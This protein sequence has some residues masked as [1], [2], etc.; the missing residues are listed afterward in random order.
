LEITTKFSKKT[1]VGEEMV[2]R[3][4]IKLIGFLMLITIIISVVANGAIY[5]YLPELAED[6][7]ELPLF[8][9]IF[10]DES[11]GAVPFTVNFTSLV[12]NYEGDIAYY[13]E[14]GD[15]NTSNEISPSYTYV[16][17]NSFQC[18]LTVS[19]SAGKEVTDSVVISVKRNQGAIAII[20]VDPVVS[21]R[22]HLW[23]LPKISETYSGG[24]I[25]TI[26]NSPIPNPRLSNL[27]GW[28]SCEG[29]ATDPEGDEIVSYTWVLKP[30]SYLRRIGGIVEY[31]E[32]TF[33]GQNITIPG[34]Y[35][36]RLGDYDLI[37]TVE[38]ETG[39]T[40]SISTKFKIGTSPTENSI[41]QLKFR[42][43]NTKDMWL[44]Q[45]SKMAFAGL[46]IGTVAN[47]F[48]R[49]TNFPRAKIVALLLL[50]TGWLIS[51]EGSDTTTFE[52]YSEFLEKHPIRKKI[53]NTTLHGI[54]SSLE[55]IKDNNPQLNETLDGII[56][57]VQG[58]L[59]KLG[60]ANNR[61]VIKDPFP[62]NEKDWVP[63]DLPYVSVTV[64]DTEDDEF[65]IRI[66]GD[67][68]TDIDLSGQY[69]GSFTADL[70]T[71]LPELE[72]ITWYVEVTDH[73]GRV[74]TEEYW[75][76]TASI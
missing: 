16:T 48:Q 43:D 40:A 39:S 37:L 70:I 20:K 62:E 29:Q 61:P 28:V 72:R 36:Y 42:R 46:V 1:G 55:K 54:L 50:Q 2:E 60:M 47:L 51:W 69:S 25:D 33:E 13:W 34:M 4:K 32:Y 67:N 52:L 30:P 21:Q 45:W 5:V 22:P 35:T 27:K 76:K 65:D 71:P 38:D 18:S 41:A 31:P 73:L 9:K 64:N 44:K 26:I 12:T 58:I 63:R 57:A 10:T 23:G 6:E 3:S 8:V 11:S 53:V 59:E 14:F 74:V 66:F 24:I 49:G 7:E 56:D 19:D 17:N 15:G 75:F 68:I